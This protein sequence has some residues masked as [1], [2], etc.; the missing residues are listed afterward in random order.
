MNEIR[1]ILTK[2]VIG[3]GQRSFE[4]NVSLPQTAIL[5]DR[6]LGAFITNHHMQ[7]AKVGNDIEL[8]GTYD[9]HCWYTHSGDTETNISKMTVEYGNRVELQ[10]A[11]REHLL[12]TDD[13]LCEEVVAP[14]ATNVR[15]EEG[16]IVADVLFEVGV[17]VIGE[18]K[19][20]VAILGPVLEHERALPV[21]PSLD[22]DDLSEIDAA[23]N[24]DFLDA[25]ID[26][27]E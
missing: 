17:E 5:P 22:F 14:Y 6:T 3:K 19:M 26:P 15:V 4:L 11:L 21:P 8:S 13:I 27:F 12:E 16:F 24:E 23:I 20:R 2:A 10:N 9:L 7:V 18:T 1:E 25:R